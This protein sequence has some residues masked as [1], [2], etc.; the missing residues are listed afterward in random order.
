MEKIRMKKAL[1][2]ILL[3][4]S[5]TQL[6]AVDLSG[7]WLHNRFYY[8]IEYTH[9]EKYSWGKDRFP[10]NSFDISIDEKNLMFQISGFGDFPIKNIE[11][12]SESEY[13]ITFY[14]DRG[15]FDV[16]Y[17][18]NLLN[19]T[20]LILKSLTEGI[21]F[22]SQGE[23]NH[24]YR[25]S[26]PKDVPKYSK[27]ITAIYIGESNNECPLKKGE[28]IRLIGFNLYNMRSFST[29]Q[30]WYISENNEYGDV[31]AT[32]IKIVDY[33]VGIVMRAS[34]NLN[35]RKEEETSS[36]IITTIRK[37]TNVKILAIDKK[38]TIDEIENNWVK[39]E[40]LDGAKDSDGNS[41][42]TGIV[43]WCFGGYLE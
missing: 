18:I 2:V 17:Q 32:S 16:Q 14:F 22:I 31:N 35:I 23:D 8:N 25:V 28:K 20:E 19:G 11:Q 21:T 5:Y 10:R 3:I 27:P 6:F 9:E 34:D 36:K 41:I 15:D 1:I 30:Y 12:L 26:G 33:D 43:G 29:L 42:K 39:I 37:G 4:L 38:E 7:V 13:I 40:I 24:Y